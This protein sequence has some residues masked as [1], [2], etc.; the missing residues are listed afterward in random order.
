MIT[1]LNGLDLRILETISQY[2][3]NPVLDKIMIGLTTLGDSGLLWI[4]FGMILIITKKYRYVGVMV[5]CA[6]LLNFI[7]VD[8]ILKNIIQ[9]PR[10]FEAIPTLN[11]LIEKPLSYSFPSGHAS[12][13]FA[14]AGILIYGFKKYRFYIIA[15]AGLMAF[16]RIYLTVH[17]PTDILA[18]MII[19]L[20]SS[21]IVIQLFEYQRKKMPVNS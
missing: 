4:L 19:G 2:I 8:G 7:V 1:V 16:T 5:L 10:P 9:R 17:Y 6:L 11:L 15:L 18:G 20:I 3:H 12:S 13:A 14:A 21:R